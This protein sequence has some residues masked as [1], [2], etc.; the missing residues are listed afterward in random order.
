[1][2][3][4]FSPPEASTESERLAKAKQLKPRKN[5]EGRRIGKG[6]EKAS[7]QIEAAQRRREREVKAVEVNAENLT[8]ALTRAEA[9]AKAAKEP[10]EDEYESFEV[11]E[12]E[13]ESEKEVPEASKDSVEGLAFI[14]NMK[15]SGVGEEPETPAEVKEE[16]SVP[17]NMESAKF[18]DLKEGQ[19]VSVRRSSGKIDSDWRVLL[20]FEQDQKVKVI[21]MKGNE[22]DSNFKTVAAAEIFVPVKTRNQNPGLP[23]VSG[24]INVKEKRSSPKK[25]INAN[26]EIEQQHIAK[27]QT[28]EVVVAPKEKPRTIGEIKEF[29]AGSNAAEVTKFGNELLQKQVENI[30]KGLDE[31][32]QYFLQKNKDLKGD[33]VAAHNFLMGEEIKGWFKGKQREQQIKYKELFNRPTYKEWLK[34]K[35]KR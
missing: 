2:S 30:Q 33:P 28:K 10:K 25:S 16:I 26:I 14:K 20:K 15:E 8:T 29:I 27:P 17:E 4:K 24:E 34:K 19:L 21:K 12:G 13:I 5:Q 3:E 9:R 11:S 22:E 35:G 7:R 23:P 31:I 6:L 1:M 32:V 18:E